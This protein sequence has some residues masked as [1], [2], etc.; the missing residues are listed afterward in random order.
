MLTSSGRLAVARLLMPDHGLYLGLAVGSG[1]TPEQYEDGHLEGDGDEQTAWHVPL[2]SGFPVLGD[3]H[4]VLQARFEDGVAQ[5]HW[6]EFGIFASE[7][8]VIAGHSLFATSENPVLI[9]RTTG[10]L[11]S[12]PKGPEHWVLRTRLVVN[13]I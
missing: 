9:T 7:N 8:P 3:G 10:L 2:D 11:H 12:E 1:M 13:P 4:I 5:F 6:R